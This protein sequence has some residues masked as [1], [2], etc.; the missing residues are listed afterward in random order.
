MIRFDRFP[1]GKYKAVTLSYDDGRDYDRRMIEIMNRYGVRGTFHLNSVRLGKPGH[2]EPS[3]ISTLFA[4]HEVSAHTVNHPFLNLSPTETIAAEILNDRLA[5]EEIVGY[6]VKGMSYPYGAWNNDVVTVLRAMGMEYARAT[7]AHGSFDMPSDFLVWS[8]TCHHR[9][10][11]EYAHKFIDLQ[12]RHSKM[13]LLYVWGHSYEFEND[14]NWQQLEQFSQLI[15]NQAD[16]WY[17][18]NSEIV[19]YMNAIRQLRCSVSG[20]IVHNPSAI[21]VWFSVNGAA[22]EVLAGEMKKLDSLYNGKQ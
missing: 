13:A 3:E 10:M 6:P 20:H 5:L 2:L 19:S 4:G 14:Q 15:G 16:I 22:V 17:A 18:T 21:S 8:P 9:D 12:M 7:S 11:L 1:Q